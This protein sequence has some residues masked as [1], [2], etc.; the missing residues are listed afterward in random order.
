MPIGAGSTSAPIVKKTNTKIK[1]IKKK[2]RE[3]YKGRITPD[4][5]DTYAEP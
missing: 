3:P 4:E 1:K 2:E 5:D